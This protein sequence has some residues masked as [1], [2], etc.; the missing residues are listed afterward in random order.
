M[1]IYLAS[2]FRFVPQVEHLAFLLE[3]MGHKI[4]CKWWVGGDTK[5]TGKNETL[6]DEEWYTQPLAKY[7][8]DRDF[9][10]V[11]DAD[12]VILVCPER[13]SFNGANVEIG[14]AIALGKIVMSVGPIERSAMYQSIIRCR[15]NLCLLRCIIDATG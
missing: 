7:I 2:A 1:K 13:H 12:I 14:Y 10:G 15:D 3:S 8:R 4:T 9:K 11:S 6:T 5:V